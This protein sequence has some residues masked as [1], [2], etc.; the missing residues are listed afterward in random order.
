[1]EAPKL[2]LYLAGDPARFAQAV[3]GLRRAARERLGPE[4]HLEVVDVL[5]DRQ[6]ALA[7][8]VHVA[9]TLLLGDPRHG[10]R[11]F[12]DLSDA[13]DALTSLGLDG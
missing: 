12:G 11:A 7:D 10:P 5:A 6:R 9:P 13:R 2:T 4:V 1:M 8:G 3:E